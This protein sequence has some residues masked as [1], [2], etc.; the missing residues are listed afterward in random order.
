MRNTAR[1]VDIAF[2]YFGFVL[3]ENGWYEDDV[4]NRIKCGRLKWWLAAGVK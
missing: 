4:K 1:K 2:N 3:Q